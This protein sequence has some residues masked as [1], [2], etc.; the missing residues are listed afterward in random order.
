[1]P[2]ASAPNGEHATDALPVNVSD[3]E[4]SAANGESAAEPDPVTSLPDCPAP[5]HPNDES[6]AEQDPVNVST[7]LLVA[8][9]AGAL[10]GTR[11][12]DKALDALAAAT[13]SEERRVG[14]ECGYQ[15]RSRWSPYH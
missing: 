7:P 6:T 11:V 10:I 5:V 1:M 9:G 15:C 4:P 12:D 14:K 13:R 8:D 2:V 3:P